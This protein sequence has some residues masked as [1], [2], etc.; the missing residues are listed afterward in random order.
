[1]NQILITIMIHFF[2]AKMNIA[3]KLFRLTVKKDKIERSYEILNRYNMFDKK[4]L[5]RASYRRYSDYYYG[6]NTFSLLYKIKRWNVYYDLCKYDPLELLQFIHG[7]YH[8]VQLNQIMADHTD[9]L[10]DTPFAI[11]CQNSQNGVVFWLKKILNINKKTMKPRRRQ[12]KLQWIMKNCNI[13]D[14]I[15]SF[16]KSCSN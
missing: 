9:D 11:A 5:K 8:Q 1:M 14:D 6:E 3:R 15:Y 7:N 10:T 2:N 4:N 16:L 13:P 12:M